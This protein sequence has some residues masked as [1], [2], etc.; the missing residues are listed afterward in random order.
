MTH[1]NLQLQVQ[2]KPPSK[3]LQSLW[4]IAAVTMMCTDHQT[5]C[6][7]QWLLASVGIFALFLQTLCLLSSTR[8]CA[9]SFSVSV[10]WYTFKL[11]VLQKGI[12]R[13]REVTHNKWNIITFGYMS[14][15]EAWFNYFHLNIHC[16]LFLLVSGHC[17]IRSISL[18]LRSRQSFGGG[19]S[20]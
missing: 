6:V 2:R 17:F 3:Q 19:I 20:H 14:R 7:L 10:F 8:I 16:Y 5:E 4:F 15:Y 1:L 11:S 13:H 18:S 9:F 12:F